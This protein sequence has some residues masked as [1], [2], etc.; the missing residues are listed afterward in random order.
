MA[1]NPRILIENVAPSV[2][3]GAFPAKA[4]IGDMCRVE[5]DIYRDGHEVLHAQL[6]WKHQSEE[7]F[8]SMPLV[9]LENDRWTALF[10]L[11]RMGRYQF[12]IE[13]WSDDKSA[14]DKTIH[15]PPF[16]LI[17]DPERAVFGSWYEMFVRSEG[18]FDDAAKRF[19]ALHDLGF[20]VV[21]LAP[22]HPIGRTARKGPNNSADAKP[23]DPG[24]P[25]AIGN[26]N[27]GHTAVEPSLGT[28]DDF[29]RFVKSAAGAG[30]AIALDF[31]PH[32]SPEHPW[33]K[34]HREW[35]YFRPDG[36]IKCHE[37]PPFVYEDVYPLNFD[38]ADKDALWKALLDVILFWVSHGVK[39][40][41][42][43]NPHTKP[44]PF[45]SW[46]IGEVKAKHPEVVFL[47]EA[48]TRPKM[49][50][51][52]SK[53]GFSQSYTYFIWRTTKAEL[54]EYMTELTQTEMPYYFRPNFFVTTPDVLPKNL[55][56]AS[57]A[58][59]KMRLALAA[60]LSPTYGIVSGYE[61]I[62][63]KALPNTEEYADSE[64]Y[65]IKRRD[66]NAAGNINDFIRKINH[67]RLDNKAF[68]RLSNFLPL[69]IANDQIFSFAR[70]SDDKSNLILAVVNLTPG[71]SQEGHVAIP[72]DKLG[73]P[74]NSR[75]QVEDLLSGASY[76]WGENN[77]V[78]LDPS[79]EPVQIFKVK[80]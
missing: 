32:C 25:W 19:P 49:M 75:Y 46:M 30:I 20:D 80:R 66:W 6:L 52:L 34:E 50:K 64:K 18:T 39:I 59:F 76:T 44:V 33:V 40:F 38:C 78:R 22:I 47:G 62:E 27:G 51:M 77:Y 42:V 72:F 5:A 29:D 13:A 7:K 79:A 28:L 14:D 2:D 37:N 63:N 73:I 65:E 54:V 53:D 8:R 71:Q 61:L 4:V 26:E 60:L 55:Q 10:P 21:Y 43:D 16:E 9:A 24:S 68:K 35:F 70:W 74:W 3:G 1:V 58:V 69:P 11:E 12:T 56:N 31:A 57:A 17:V 45:W 48:F 23:S 36:T 15:E 41:R 67:I